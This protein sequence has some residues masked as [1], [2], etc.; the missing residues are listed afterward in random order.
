MIPA[1]AILTAFTQYDQ[2]EEERRRAEAL[3]C[4]EQNGWPSWLD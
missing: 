3:V 1:A 4:R 2:R